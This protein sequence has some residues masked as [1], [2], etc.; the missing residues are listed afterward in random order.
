MIFWDKEPPETVLR[1]PPPKP[2]LGEIR[3]RA[4]KETLARLDRFSKKTAMLDPRSGRL[5]DDL[6]IYTQV[7][8]KRRL[9]RDSLK[10]V[11][12][13]NAAERKR[14]EALRRLTPLERARKV[15]ED[16]HRSERDRITAIAGMI[17]REQKQ[18][19]AVHARSVNSRVKATAAAR[20]RM[21]VAQ[22]LSVP[23]MDWLPRG[24]LPG[25]LDRVFMHTFRKF[26]PCRDQQVRKEVMHAKRLHHGHRSRK[27]YD[28]WSFGPC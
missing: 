12:L 24:K 13:Q 11:E 21:K 22:G 9:I 7:S 20:R 14:S 18:L 6:N 17:E 1:D 23:G 3:Q 15:G 16:L 5:S 19:A 26:D 10:A 27:R 28:Q 2:N 8:E 25:K 4:L